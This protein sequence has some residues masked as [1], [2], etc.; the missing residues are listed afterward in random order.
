M[1]SNMTFRERCALAAMRESLRT[2]YR[3]N[4]PLVGETL[5]EFQ[6]G[7]ADGAWTMADAMDA[8]RQKRAA[9]SAPAPAETPSPYPPIGPDRDG[10]RLEMAPNGDG[11]VRI[12]AHNDPAQP[13]P[14]DAELAKLRAVAGAAGAYAHAM[15]S[16]PI[17]D[18]DF[19]KWTALCDALESACPGWRAKEAGR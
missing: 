1:S 17:I 13:D 8:E 18:G 11:T 4:D 14:R 2:E 6:A 19:R 10:T 16:K 12:T 5:E 9:M 7:V 3:N 15:G